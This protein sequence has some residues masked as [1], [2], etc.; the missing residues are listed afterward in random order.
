MIKPKTSPLHTLPLAEPAT[1]EHTLSVVLTAQ[2]SLKPGHEILDLGCGTA[3][4]AIFI[5]ERYPLANVTG[6]DSDPY[7]LEIALNKA[8]SRH[9]HVK[10]DIGRLDCLP[11]RDNSFDVVVANRLHGLPHRTQVSVLLESMRVLKP[12]GELYIGSSERGVSA[13]IRHLGAMLRLPSAEVT[14]EMGQLIEKANISGK[15]EILRLK[16]LFSETTLY[17]VVKMI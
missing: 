6:L 2:L 13:L 14:A 5:K 12:H 16:T 10:L 8:R 11:Y 9:V 15:V 7:L 4:L 3:K 17:R 1:I